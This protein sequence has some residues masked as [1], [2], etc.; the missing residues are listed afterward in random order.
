MSQ[1]LS[2]KLLQRKAVELREKKINPVLIF[3]GTRYLALQIVT[4]QLDDKFVNW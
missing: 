3:T 1:S 4:D 2:I